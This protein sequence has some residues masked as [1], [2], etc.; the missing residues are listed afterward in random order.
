M[1]VIK[2]GASSDQLTIDPTSKAARVTIYGSDGG[3]GGERAS[4][5]AATTATV[6]AAAGSAMFFVI[7]GSASKTIKIW[8][9][10]V[11]GETLTTLAVNSVVME[12][13]STAPTGGVAVALTAVP[14]DSNDA[15]ASA[16]LVQVYTTAPTEGSL[17]GTIGC[18]RHLHKS[19]TIVDGSAFDDVDW[20]FG[21]QNEVRPVVLRG[22]AQALSLAF[23]ASPASAV[24]L[25]VEV[26]WTE[27]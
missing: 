10:R 7:A 24:T 15:A 3:Y 5:R 4:Y 12:K 23:G 17:I 22:S 25:A 2:S 9:I 8:H 20:A 13:W 19:S 6:V 1:A 27:E 18:N 21:T 11:S 16:S 26:E 14:L